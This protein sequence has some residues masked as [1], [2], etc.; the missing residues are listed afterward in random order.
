M[1]FFAAEARQPQNG[2][3]AVFYIYHF[4]HYKTYWYLY[5]NIIPH[6]SNNFNQKFIK[7]NFFSYK[8]YD[9][10]KSRTA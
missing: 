6:F 2:I 7:N 4:V 9:E 8:S 1:S 5:K 10:Q 3:S